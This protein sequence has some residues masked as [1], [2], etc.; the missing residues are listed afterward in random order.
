MV[1]PRGLAFGVACDPL[2]ANMEAFTRDRLSTF[3]DYCYNNDVQIM[4]HRR[5]ARRLLHAALSPDGGGFNYPAEKVEKLEAFLLDERERHEG[6]S[7]YAF[8]RL[9]GE[10]RRALRAPPPSSS[11]GPYEASASPAP[12]AAGE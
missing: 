8:V 12:S 10:L 1:S 2:K 3:L 6:V 7:V 9:L 11:F 5:E 4:V